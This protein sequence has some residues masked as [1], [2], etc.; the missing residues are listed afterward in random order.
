MSAFFALLLFVCSF[1]LHVNWF[2]VLPLSVV[3]LLFVKSGRNYGL[4]FLFVG[5][6]FS[7]YYIA[8][9]VYTLPHFGN[10]AVVLRSKSNY[11]VMFK[12]M[13]FYYVQNY[14]NTFSFG[15]IISINGN[16]EPLF[17]I[18]LESE[19]DFKQ[20]LQSLGVHESYVSR[21]ITLVR[22][23]KLFTFFNSDKRT[24]HLDSKTQALLNMLLSGERSSDT[25][26]PLLMPLA[27][28]S[29]SGFH[30][31]LIRRGVYKVARISLNS[32]HALIISYGV[33]C[34]LFLFNPTKF[35]F[36]RIFLVAILRVL[37]QK[38]YNGKFD[39]FTLNALSGLLFVLANPFLIMNPAFYLSYTLILMFSL[40]TKL[41]SKQYFSDFIFVLFVFI[42][43][44]ITTNAS[45]HPLSTLMQV[46]FAPLYFV[47]LILFFLSFLIAPLTN[48]TNN[49][50]T[51]IL[52]LNAATTNWR[53]AL[54][55][56]E[57]ASYY[58]CLLVAVLLVF[59][60]FKQLGAIT[61]LRNT[62]ALF[63]CLLLIKVVPLRNHFVT[64]VHFINVGQG[65]S[66]LLISRGQS[67]LIDTGGLTYKD[68]GTNVLMPFLRKKQITKLD[69]VIITHDH[70]DH[71]GA[72][73]TLVD[74][75]YVKNVVTAKT[76]FPLTVGG[77]QIS[78]L[79]EGGYAEENMNSLMLYFHTMN[80]GFLITGDAYRG[81]EENIVKKYPYLVI[82][83]L[84][85]G[86]HGSNT[87][88]SEQFIRHFKPEQAIISCGYQ[89]KFGHPE[90]EVLATLAK[91]NVLVRRTDIEGTIS[92]QK[93]L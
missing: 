35:A 61:K 18:T 79:N 4:L 80:K 51:Y 59:Y 85:V 25:N 38:F 77:V 42:I 87:S 2:F 9:F 19:F 16:S 81:N 26:D 39:N 69:Y 71:N 82:D 50:A 13:R 46:L 64:S 83:V 1:C 43:Y 91:Y 45:F 93:A 29:L 54:I 10:Y 14:N 66:T 22:S 23:A 44:E 36:Y 53:F 90:A 40:Q 32:K 6:G 57:V 20:Y 28:L 24:A 15:D 56:G 63:V 72:L 62:G 65:D 41:R 12:S 47:L 21:D 37:N 55:T 92:F 60:Y 17:F 84:K 88:T 33:L 68:V 48:I 67:V 75:N 58:A 31:S 89:N 76:S 52:K 34:L 70:F 11:F 30:L 8:S 5:A 3:V 27:F 74:G 7:S 86:H 73:A 49:F 78:N